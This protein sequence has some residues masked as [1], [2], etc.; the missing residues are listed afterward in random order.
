[1]SKKHKHVPVTFHAPACLHLV[2]LT[3]VLCITCASSFVFRRCHPKGEKC[4]LCRFQPP[5]LHRKHSFPTFRRRSSVRTNTLEHVSGASRNNRGRAGCGR[6]PSG[7]GRRKL[8]LDPFFLQLI[9]EQALWSFFFPTF[10]PN[11]ESS[12]VVNETQRLAEIWFLLVLPD[13]NNKNVKGTS[14]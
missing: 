1:M 8:A 2:V 12:S 5:G 11:L 3:F 7:P 14:H 6:G 9:R 4:E 13:H 10:S